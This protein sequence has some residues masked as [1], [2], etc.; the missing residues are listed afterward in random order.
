MKFRVTSPFG[1]LEEFRSNPH[2]G[3]D[4]AMQEG[5]PI[6]AIADG[7]IH[8]KDFG[9]V[10]AGKTVLL[11][12][13]DGTTAIFGHLKDF[14]VKDGQRVSANDLLAHSGSSGHSTGPHLHFGL[15]DQAG[16]FL[17]PSS[18]Q[19]DIQN[20][21][22]MPAPKESLWQKFL[23]RGEVNNFEHADFSIWQDIL[24]IP[25]DQVCILVGVS[26]LLL[27]FKPIRTYV[28]GTMAAVLLIVGGVLS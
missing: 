14:A 22:S 8:L 7:V 18:Y 21:A 6:R 13:N 25:G 3:I 19:S 10:N 4:F 15:K 5:T 2:T 11:E 27:L 16:R 12:M 26:V 1:S 28:I 17:D 9:D 24:G 20:M 23:E